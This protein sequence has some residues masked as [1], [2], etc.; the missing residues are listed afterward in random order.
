MGPTR[1]PLTKL[2]GAHMGFPCGPH[3]T[4]QMGPRWVPHACVGWVYVRYW[5]EGQ[6][7]TRFLSA[8]FLG[9]ATA[10]DVLAK[11]LAS[12]EGLKFFNR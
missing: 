12:L 9:R 3:F 5:D 11:L 8:K 4:R 2:Y 7:Q 1:H 6:V 10:D